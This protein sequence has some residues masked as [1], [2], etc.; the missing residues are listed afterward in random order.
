MGYA[1]IK[2][3]IKDVRL[4]GKTIMLTGRTTGAGR[5]QFGGVLLKPDITTRFVKLISNMMHDSPIVEGFSALF[6]IHDRDRHSPAALTTHTPVGAGFNHVVDTVTPPGRNP[7]DP[8]D[9][10]QRLLPQIVVFHADKPLLGSTK[11]HRFF[12]APAVRIAMTEVALVQQ[13]SNFQQFVVHCTVGVSQFHTAKQSEFRAIATIIINRIVNIQA[14]LEANH[15]VIMTMP[16]GR[17]HTTGSGFEGDMV[18]KHDQG[19]ALVKGMT[20]ILVVEFPCVERRN[21]HGSFNAKSS[22]NLFP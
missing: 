8:L 21:H 7:L 3:D 5:E 16:G 22:L 1:G 2:P 11:N 17:M 12:T 18:T 15:I 4:F 6:T 10:C 14:I 19:I 9:L 20:T 13:G